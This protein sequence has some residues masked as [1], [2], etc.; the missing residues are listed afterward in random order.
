[1]R[2]SLFLLILLAALAA[3]SCNKKN[4]K[5]GGSTSD[6][7]KLLD[8]S[9]FYARELY[10][11]YDQ[12][13]TTFNP[14]NYDDPNE[15]MEAIRP[16]SKETGFSSA[17]DRWS[18]AVTE[19]EWNDISQG[20]AGDFGLGVFFASN[21]DL[22]VSYVEKASPAGAAT[23][24]RGWRIKKINNMTSISTNY[25]DAIVDAIFYSSNGTFVFGRD[26]KADTTIT[27][28]ATTYV[29][30]PIILDTIYTTGNGKA[31]YLVYN[32]FLG[33]TTRTKQAFA[34]IFTEWSQEGVTDAIIDLRY[35]GGGYVLL[36]DELANYLVNSSG[37][38]QVMEKQ[39][40]NK[41]LTSWNETTN[42]RK[43]GSLNLSRLFVI[44]SQ[45]TASASELL[46]N[47][48]RP[49]L[50]VQLVGPSNTHGKAVGYFG[51]PVEDWLIFP[52]SFRTLNKNNEGNYFDGFTPNAQVADGLDKNW[53]DVTENCLAAALRYINT[54]VY[55]QSVGTNG[56][57]T[58]QTEI[59]ELLPPNK[60]L[61]KT[62]FKGAVAGIRQL[63]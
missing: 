5:G 28:T 62:R 3:V 30:Q 53:G 45:N 14:R 54:G 50:N 63:P 52:V 9:L 4:D 21:S 56:N 48:L 35:N 12:I 55:T 61:G 44:V 1:M 18:F 19:E 24:K 7:D 51:Y 34:D 41:K 31:G 46:I 23:I 57:R 22:R 40:F 13:P 20:I 42:F 11:W 33:D 2:S 26:N 32:S 29:E 36:Q 60:E 43:K 38:N 10:L 59:R 39:V 58:G 27:L 25:V 37:N 15:V 49:F 6:K 47:S 16:Y 8:S 17:V